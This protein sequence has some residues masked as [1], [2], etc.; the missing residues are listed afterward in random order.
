M[1]SKRVGCIRR[2]VIS[3]SPA[4]FGLNVA[5]KGSFVVLD[6]TVPPVG[7]DDDADERRADV[8]MSNLRR[9]PASLISVDPID[10]DMDIFV[11]LWLRRVRRPPLADDEV[12]FVRTRVGDFESF[13]VSVVGFFIDGEDRLDDDGPA[14]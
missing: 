11:M 13:G 2:S 4:V 14:S 10:A 7:L 8:D 5:T 1:G 6:E 9:P 12:V 3:K